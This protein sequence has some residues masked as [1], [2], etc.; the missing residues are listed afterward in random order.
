MNAERGLVTI[1]AR[2]VQQQQLWPARVLRVCSAVAN[3]RELVQAQSRPVNPRAALPLIIA[4]TTGLM[5]RRPNTD[6]PSSA[7]GLRRPTPSSLQLTG[8]CLSRPDARS[9][10]SLAQRYFTEHL[11]KPD[12]HSLNRHSNLS[13][14]VSLINLDQTNLKKQDSTKPC[15]LV[16][17]LENFTAL[18]EYYVERA[19]SLPYSNPLTAQ[20]TLFA[21]QQM[22][23]VVTQVCWRRRLI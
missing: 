20:T 21:S 22:E 15:V 7:Q 12:P 19:S 6:R 10:L 8:P 1:R 3:P 4:A 17:G 2:L 9:G 5:Q 18:V 14:E 16:S 23:N 13:S 11:L